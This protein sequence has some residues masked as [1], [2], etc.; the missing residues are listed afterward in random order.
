MFVVRQIAVASML[1]VAPDSAL[2]SVHLFSPLT[3]VTVE[4][5]DVGAKSIQIDPL[6]SSLEL[7]LKRSGSEHAA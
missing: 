2:P 1:A 7:T 6:L 3:S 5:I 4:R